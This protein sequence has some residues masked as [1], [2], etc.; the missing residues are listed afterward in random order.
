MD[1]GLNREDSGNRHHVGH[2]KQFAK[3]LTLSK[4]S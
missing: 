1:D 4:G 2:Y 3:N